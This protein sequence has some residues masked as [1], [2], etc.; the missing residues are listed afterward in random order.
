MHYLSLLSP[1]ILPSL[2]VIILSVIL[3]IP[4]SWVTIITVFPDLL[5]SLRSSSTSRPVFWSSAP[6]GC[7]KLVQNKEPRQ[8]CCLPG[9]SLT[10]LLCLVCLLLSLFVGQPCIWCRC[11]LLSKSPRTSSAIFPLF[12]LLRLPGLIACA[13]Q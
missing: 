6:V 4:S 7:V 5:I 1:T 3:A 12:L 8:G 13:V 9:S 2:I 11:I 10:L